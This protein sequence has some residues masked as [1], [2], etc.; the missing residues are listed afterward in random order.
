MKGELARG[1]VIIEAVEPQI[2]CGRHRSKAVTL[3]RQAG[4]NFVVNELAHGVA[5]TRFD[6]FFRLSGFP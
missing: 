5:Q 1:H 6:A 4:I 2:A 3:Y